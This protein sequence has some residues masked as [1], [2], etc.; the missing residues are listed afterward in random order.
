MRK[1]IRALATFGI[2]PGG[3]GV[4]NLD[5]SFLSSSSTFIAGPG[6]KYLWSSGI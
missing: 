4:N 5:L 3:L 2:S 1:N 6:G